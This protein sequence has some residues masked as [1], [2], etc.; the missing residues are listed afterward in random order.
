VK[1]V[2]RWQLRGLLSATGLLVLA[3]IVILAVGVG[4]VLR[5]YT[6]IQLA[7]LE[8][9]AQAI[10]LGGSAEA[11]EFEHAGSFFVF[12]ADGALVYSNR[13]RGRSL[14]QEQL[15]PITYDGTTIGYFFAEGVRFLE[16]SANQ[17]LLA[18]LGVLAAASILVS[19][20]VAVL[21]AGRSAGRI[22]HAVGVLQTDLQTVR[23]LEPVKPREF[24]ITE[25]TQMSRTMHTVSTMLADE[26]T[27][28]RRWM[29][30][31]AHD[32][33]SPLSGLKGQ[34]EGMRDG[35]LDPSSERFAR[36]LRDVER[37][38]EMVA[39]ITELHA[40]EAMATLDTE[41]IDLAGLFH[42]IESSYELALA[43]T[44][45]KLESATSVSTVRAHRGL[46]LRAV[47]NI[48]QNAIRYG[49]PGVSIQLSARANGEGTSIVIANDGPSIPEDQLE[50]VFQRF[51]RGEF[52]R[53][54]QGSGLGLSIAH[55]IAA[56]HG[57]S[58]TARNLEPAGVEFTLTL[59][60][61]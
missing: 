37:L 31:I 30:D 50:R 41:E 2:Y 15:Q 38:E 58:L 34:L 28:K 22:S 6:R 24:Q 40:I 26:E 11:E 33:R 32:L 25:L 39:S 35:V 42:E 1:S 7:R 36:T 16:S 48:I 23:S 54:T 27:Y 8:E 49:G 3:Q 21:V 12:S 59:P 51:F 47:G 61:R 17:Y 20:V 60:Q 4:A 29:Q 9:R 44:D 43:N 53:N 57:G 55:Q 56:R 13:G 52:A 46:L 10:L 14:P 19:A 5:S 45:A 18:S